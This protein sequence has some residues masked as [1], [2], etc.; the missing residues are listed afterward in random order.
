[1][2]LIFVRHAEPVIVEA[3]AGPPDPQLSE[4]GRRQA[5]AVAAW[6]SAEPIAAIVH[7]TARRTRETAERIGAA[8]GLEPSGDPGFLE[9]NTSDPDYLTVEELRRRGDPRYA[10]VARGE[11][12]GVDA[13]AYQQ[14]VTDAAER[15]IAAYPGTKVVVVSHAGAINCYTSGVA[16]VPK[17]LWIPPAFAS[18]TRVGASRDG[19]RGI[20]SI[21]ETGHLRSVADPAPGLASSS[22]RTVS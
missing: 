11:L 22:G 17:M 21:N 13:V 7:S 9:F 4:Q 14:Q 16:G 3:G 15:L 5:A 12:Y 6:L 18:I 10:S 19:R 8:L 1:M 2:E 20:N